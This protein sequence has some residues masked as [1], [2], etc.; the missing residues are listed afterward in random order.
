[1]DQSKDSQR[2]NNRAIEWISNTLKPIRLLVVESLCDDST[3]VPRMITF[4]PPYSATRDNHSGLEFHTYTLKENFRI[5]TKR[6]L[7]IS[8]SCRLS[9]QKS[10]DC[11]ASTALRE[12]PLYSDSIIKILSDAYQINNF[13]DTLFLASQ[14]ISFAKIWVFTMALLIRSNDHID[15]SE[16]QTF[17]WWSWLTVGTEICDLVQSNAHSRC[18]PDWDRNIGEQM[19]AHFQIVLTD[20]SVNREVIR[21]NSSRT[22]L[23][24]P[25]DIRTWRK[26]LIRSE[27]DVDDV[28]WPAA[29]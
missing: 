23:C 8:Y 17:F 15:H 29:I 21:R 19:H 13:C 26:D 5:Q 14:I 10:Q 4:L 11:F 27:T 22:G 16:V 7:D 1:M 28:F 18:C 25:F 2:Y 6:L 3:L 9:K 24:P 20:W 12:D